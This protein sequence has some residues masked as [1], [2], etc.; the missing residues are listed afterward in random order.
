M[1]VTSE[2]TRLK[3][4]IQSLSDE[5]ATGTG[6]R[7]K[8]PLSPAEKRTTRAELQSLIQQLDELAA[9]LAG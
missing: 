1:S 8:A 6:P 4:D 2:L 5:I 9:R 3:R 7:P